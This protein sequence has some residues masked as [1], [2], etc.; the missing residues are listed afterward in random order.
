M[1]SPATSPD[2]RPA[3]CRARDLLGRIGDKWSL[4][5]ISKLGEHTLRFTDLKRRVDGI[6]QRMLTVTL[7]GLERDGI[8]SRT[9]YPVV[10]PRVD[11]ALTPMG[12]TLLATVGTLINW[13]EDHVEDIENARAAYDVRDTEATPFQ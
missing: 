7:R 12:R 4:Y 3:A 13:A 11:Y 1:R 8:V 9:V 6:S 5:V 2:D 10:P